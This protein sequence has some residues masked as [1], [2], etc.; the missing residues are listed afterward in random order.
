M[1]RRAAMGYYDPLRVPH[2]ITELSMTRFN[3][4]ARL[5]ILLALALL[6][7]S[8]GRWGKREDVL[9]TLPLEGL[10]AEA[11]KALEYGNHSRAQRYYQ[12]LI[13]R[14]PYGPY[15]EQAQIEL[16]YAYYKGNKPE[17]ATSTISRFVRT[18]P[19]H[20]YIDTCTT[21]AA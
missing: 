10:Y 13:A 18:Y 21:C 5:A 6:L 3:G 17:D 16:A 9:E 2:G 15:T 4:I 8:C 11:K 20:P 7:S 14:F 19:A 12:R 1:S